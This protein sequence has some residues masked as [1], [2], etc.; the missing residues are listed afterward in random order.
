MDTYINFL[1][2]PV[3]LCLAISKWKG[4][5]LSEK[6]LPDWSVLCG[7][8]FDLGEL[9]LQSHPKLAVRQAVLQRFVN[10]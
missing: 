1:I 4:F 8:N 10:M 7:L 2:L 5:S 6:M 3:F 9:A